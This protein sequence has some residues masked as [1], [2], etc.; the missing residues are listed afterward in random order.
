MGSTTDSRHPTDWDRQ[1]EQLS[2]FV[3]GELSPA[4]R[5][6]LERHLATCLECQEELARL[7]HVHALLGALPTPAVPRSFAL[8]SAAPT[9]VTPRNTRQQTGP[10]RERA[11]SD[12]VYRASRWIGG[13]A[14]SLGLALLLGS[15]LMSLLSTGTMG[16]ATTASSA[17]GGAQSTYLPYAPTSVTTPPGAIIVQSP[18]A[19]PPTTQGAT[20]ISAQPE[21]IPDNGGDTLPLGPLAGAGLLVGGVLVLVAGRAARSRV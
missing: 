1:R 18:P 11:G 14:A 7:R 12:A 13:I 3:D 6:E 9:T 8:P 19:T 4:E 10:G 17:L 16:A 2:A 20:H 21:P 15:A 5:V